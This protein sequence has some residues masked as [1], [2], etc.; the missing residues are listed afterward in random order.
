MLSTAMPPNTEPILQLLANKKEAVGKATPRAIS[1][2]S[3]GA[4]K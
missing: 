2:T 3:G 1:N 4:G